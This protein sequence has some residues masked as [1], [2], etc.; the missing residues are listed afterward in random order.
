MSK[1]CPHCGAYARIK[2]GFTKKTGYQRYKCCS[3]GKC[4]SDSPYPKGSLPVGAEPKPKSVSDMERRRKKRL[5][6]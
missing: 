5:I 3:C 1:V 2:I 6:Q 4:S